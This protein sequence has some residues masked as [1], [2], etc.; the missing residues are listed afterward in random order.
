MNQNKEEGVV[1]MSKGMV[2]VGVA[3]AL[4][5]II[6]FFVYPNI[7]HQKGEL[8]PDAPT[9]LAGTAGDGSIDL[10]W[11]APFDGGSP[12]TSY[13][14]KY[15][16]VGGKNE[17]IVDTRSNKSL[18]SLTG[19][20]NG[21]TYV[22]SV[23]AVNAIGEGVYST[24]TEVGLDSIDVGL[25]PSAPAN[26]SATGGQNKVPLTWDAAVEKGSAVTD[27]IVAYR[28]KNSGLDYTEISTKSTKTVYSVLDLA[29]ATI[30][31]F[32]VY[33]V[34]DAGNSVA[35][36]AVSATT[37]PALDPGVDL[38]LSTEPAVTVTSNSAEITWGTSKSASSQVYY[39]AT[40][41]MGS[42]TE[43]MNT[44]PMVTGH[45][46]SLTSLA[47]CTVYVY[48][49]ASYDEAENFVES[50]AGEFTTAGCKGDAS[51]I[52][53]SK[54]KATALAGVT[55]EAKVAG[56]GLTVTVPPAV[57]TGSDVAIQ[58]LKVS[59]AEVVAEI[60]KPTGKE[61]IGSP[62]ILNAIE[63]ASTE[64]TSFD[65]SVTVS[66]DYQNA[67][68]EGIDPDTL[69]IWHYEDGTGWR[70]LTSCYTEVNG[71]GGTV[72]CQTDSFSVFGIFGQ[73][74]S[75]GSSSGGSSTTSSGSIPKVVDNGAVT[76]ATPVT[77]ASPVTPTTPSVN[78]NNNFSFTKNLWVGIRDMDVKLLQRFL[79]LK[80]F[81]VST[82]GPGSAG[83]ETE[84]FGA[85]TKQ[86][87]IKFQEAYKVN[88]LTPIGLNLGTGFFGPQTRNY[89]N[90]MSN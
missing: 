36:D 67:D 84:F 22:L 25:P 57:V 31:E 24:T 68:I 75:G 19:L 21:Q 43:K 86:A 4:A 63:N 28:V 65:K 41:S 79:N 52:T 88:I 11:T 58:A 56:R 45:T 30:Y 83:Q 12:I 5:L 18:Y 59:K 85:K 27:Y 20:T 60:A 51:V 9:D 48:K 42:M 10:T 17:T 74:T 34:S 77:P 47:P 46:V 38:S 32:I 82:D 55:V 37:L 33:A 62:Y 64:V 7:L 66:I 70:E 44:T 6:G 87:L 89:I 16:V 15:D 26:L 3:L 8:P 13:N 35:S 49:V 78:E 29:D 61:W 71:V 69:K 73:A 23:S 72:N 90:S 39:G 2:G 80:G 53:Y 81:T 40:D 14:V 1:E 76:P 54:D 50:T